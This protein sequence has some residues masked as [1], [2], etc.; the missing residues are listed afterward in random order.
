MAHGNFIAQGLQFPKSGHRIH[1]YVRQETS[2]LT[3]VVS[4]CLG[5]NNLNFIANK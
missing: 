5:L 3:A 1:I 2:S 4:L